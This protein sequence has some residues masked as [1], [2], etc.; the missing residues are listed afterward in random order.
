[1]SLLKGAPKTKQNCYTF[2]NLDTISF[3]WIKS[4]LDGHDFIF[5]GFFN[6][7]SKKK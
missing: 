7:S 1:M 6:V 2:K 4:P 3:N 5:D